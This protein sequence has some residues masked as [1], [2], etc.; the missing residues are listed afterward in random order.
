MFTPGIST[1]YWKARNK[2]FARP[3]V[4][5][6]REQVAAEIGDGAFAD[7]VAFAA[8]EHRGER[9]LAGAVRPHD[10]V[11]LAGIHREIDPAQDL[12]A[13]DEPRMQVL[14][15]EHQFELTLGFTF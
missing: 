8:G 13:V 14:D 3:L 5:L 12:A 7:L 4:G 15:F 6:H 9:A 2:P 1:G 10:R 11:H